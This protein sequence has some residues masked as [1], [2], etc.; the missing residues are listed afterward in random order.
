MTT[1]SDIVKKAQW[2]CAL[3]IPGICVG[4]QTMPCH[5]NMQ[6]LGK[7]TGIKAGDCV[8]SGCFACHHEIDNGKALSRQDAQW[9]QLRGFAITYLR[10]VS[11]GYIIFFL[12]G[13]VTAS[14]KISELPV[15]GKIGFPA[16]QK[17]PNKKAAAKKVA[18]KAKAK[19]APKKKC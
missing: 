14:R 10:A 5:P 15:M 4:G 9:Y 19:K 6:S 7:G 1:L 18:K 11:A 12:N 17:K 16:E 13:A 8:A 3:Q 2:E